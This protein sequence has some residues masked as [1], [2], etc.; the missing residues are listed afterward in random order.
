MI[1]RH[2]N[3]RVTPRNCDHNTPACRRRISAECVK[4]GEVGRSDL[5]QRNIQ[6]EIGSKV[7][8]AHPSRKYRVGDKVCDMPVAY[9]IPMERNAEKRDEPSV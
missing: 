7:A 8:R 2:R 4:P 5:S 9:K 1:Y 3:E 6:V